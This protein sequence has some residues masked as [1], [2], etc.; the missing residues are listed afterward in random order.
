[1]RVLHV[2]PSLAPEWGG[3]ARVIPE[4]VSALVERG[5]EVDMV[6]GSGIRVGEPRQG[7][8]SVRAFP[9]GRWARW[10]TG[11]SR[12]IGP[13]MDEVAREYDLVH[14]H[15]L[16]HYFNY[17]S[18]RAA[19]R[20]GVPYVVTT[21]GNLSRAARG[22][23][24]FRKRVYWSLIQKRVLERSAAIQVHSRRE[25]I[26]VEESGV[27]A[28]VVVVPNGVA[29]PE[30][31]VTDG[32]ECHAKY[33]H[34]AGMTVIMF[35]GRVAPIKGLDSLARAFVNLLNEIPNA[36]LVIAGPRE[37]TGTVS[38]V[39]E[40]IN[41]AGTAD[42]VTWT[43]FVSDPEKAEL[44]ERADVF[45]MPSLA[46]SFGVTAAE[47]MMAGV[48]VVINRRVAFDGLDESMVVF[49]D[50]SHQSIADGIRKAL[51]DS[52]ASAERA[53]KAKALV[54]KD[55]S[56]ESVAQKIEDLYRS[57]LAGDAET[58]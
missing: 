42:R 10:W 30:R 53:A 43:G 11:Y 27:S 3:P 2:A 56:W 1:M 15:E 5:I 55:L 34:L 33:E 49:T 16:W 23:K 8:H 25:L 24:S 44:F 50:G 22:I 12:G 45:V 32:T 7:L 48:P 18:A 14:I 39:E 4:L 13:F 17:R 20:H 19:T 9:T 58:R 36:H 31:G 28:P 40:I 47:A 37:D 51:G 38:T 46:E 6:T 57:V 29:M 21:H 41:R 52:R 35:L 54:L 26:E